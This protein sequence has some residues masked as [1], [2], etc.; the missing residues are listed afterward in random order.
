MSADPGVSGFGLT[1]VS[2]ET[3][4]ISPDPDLPSANPE[5]EAELSDSDSSA[6]ATNAQFN[7]V[8]E[9]INFDAL[10]SVVLETRLKR[11]GQVSLDIIE[12]TDN[13]TCLIEEKPLFGSFNV[14]FVITF[15]DNVKWIARFPGYGVSS[16]GELEARRLLSDIRTKRLVRS[17]TSIPVPEVFAWELIRTTRSEHLIIWRHLLKDGHWQNGGREN[18]SQMNRRR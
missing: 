3:E 17:S 2:T 7:P 10:K 13:L 12:K 9:A 1:L 15:S 14:V 6:A 5:D 4:A 8:L 18:G 11:N 16:F